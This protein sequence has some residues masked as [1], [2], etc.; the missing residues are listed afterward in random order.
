MEQYA[1][2][3]VKEFKEIWEGI[4]ELVKNQNAALDD[5]MGVLEGI[6]GRLDALSIRVNQL[7]R[8][9]NRLAHYVGHATAGT[10]VGQDNWAEGQPAHWQTNVPR[11]M[12][13]QEDYGDVT[14]EEEPK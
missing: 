1:G 2:I 14:V 9:H 8:A 10:T 3:L 7:E 11:G 4:N 6:D 5:G 12:Y 13:N